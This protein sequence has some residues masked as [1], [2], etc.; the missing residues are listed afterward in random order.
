MTLL[1]A[2]AAPVHDFDGNTFTSLAAPSRGA[3]ETAAWRVA[4]PAGHISDAPHQLSREEVIF[5]LAGRAVATLGSACHTV[6]PGDTIIV[7]AFTDFRLGNPHDTP[8]EAIA[9]LP[10]GGRALLPGR[11]PFIPP[12]AA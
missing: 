11:A 7:P 3:A 10:V 2:A 9:V 4:I 8:F 5:V 6:L 1:P 12:W